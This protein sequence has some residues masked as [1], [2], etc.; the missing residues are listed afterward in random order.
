[1]DGLVAVFAIAAI[2]VAAV[3]AKKGHVKFL[4]LSSLM[5]IML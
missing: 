1:L 3:A 2:V 4:A 5:F